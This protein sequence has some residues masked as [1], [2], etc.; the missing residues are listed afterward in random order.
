MK[1]GQD[2][3]T[4]PIEVT[5]NEDHQ[6]NSNNTGSGYYLGDENKPFNSQIRQTEAEAQFYVAKREET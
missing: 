6:Y 4:I 3:N 2:P 5:M 1:I